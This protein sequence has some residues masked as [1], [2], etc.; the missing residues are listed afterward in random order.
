MADT[1]YIDILFKGT[2]LK[3]EFIE[4]IN[5]IEDNKDIDEYLSVFLLT[6]NL[7]DS[8]I[9]LNNFIKHIYNFNK[10]FMS[11]IIDL[12]RFMN[13]FNEEYD[14]ELI[15]VVL[16]NKEIKN[17]FVLGKNIDYQMIP[18]DCQKKFIDILNK[19]TDN[20]KN[21]NDKNINYDDS[22]SIYIREIGKYEVLSKEEERDI[23]KK[24]KYN[25]DKYAY[26]YFIKHNLRLVFSIAKR[27]NSSG[28]DFLELI[29]EGNIGLMD[30]IENFDL[31]YNIKFSSYASYNIRQRITRYIDNNERNIR[32]PIRKRE[33]IKKIKRSREKLSKENYS[34]PTFEEIAKDTGFTSEKVQKLLYYDTFDISLDSI[35]SNKNYINSDNN[36][37]RVSDFVSDT[38]SNFED[39]VMN[40]MIKD[41]LINAILTS[42][43]T[44]Q[45]IEIIFFRFGIYD[46]NYWTLDFI[47]KLYNI[48]R[49][50]IRQKQ[51]KSLRILRNNVNIK[52]IAN[53]NKINSIYNTVKKNNNF[54]V[55]I[56]NM[57]KKEFI[58]IEDLNK[59]NNSSVCFNDG[60]SCYLWFNKNKDK[61]LNSD[62]ILDV[63][64]KQQ[65]DYFLNMKFVD[66][67][68]IKSSV[69]KLSK[70]NII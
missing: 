12:C 9:I 63:K 45:E 42:R 57:R 59:F 62:N 56:N 37:S 4:Y 23:L 44:E 1:N 38:N 29:Q 17:K 46:G 54:D 47:A 26:E 8:K 69:K 70:D 35:I 52:K 24:I 10:T 36:D 66:D 20:R 50:R 39:D 32:L 22:I 53:I 61:I 14:Y 49:E 34:E 15:D 33:E 64:I 68:S 6:I 51:E 58:M 3:E 65:Y 40:N 27:F 16:S 18:S 30:A 25:D 31:S 28:V 2:N 55:I 7:N 60:L 21:I 19:I 5:I 13:C 48:T 67:S 11:K 43:L 41:D